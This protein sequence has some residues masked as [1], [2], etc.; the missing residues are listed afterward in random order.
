MNLP[1]T[2]L[3]CKARLLPQEGDSF[4]KRRLKTEERR[5]A[6]HSPEQSRAPCRERLIGLIYQIETHE[7]VPW[8]GG[9]VRTTRKGSDLPEAELGLAF[10]IGKQPFWK[11]ES[12]GRKKTWAGG[13]D[14]RSQHNIFAGNQGS[15][16]VAKRP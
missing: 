1:S 12:R 10:V 3:R 4:Q 13:D 16:S 2:A 15:V 8:G 5:G 7:K 6:A 14:E 11:R 9:K